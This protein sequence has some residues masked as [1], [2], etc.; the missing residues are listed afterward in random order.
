[1]EPYLQFTK[2]GPAQSS[3]IRGGR[4]GQ[5]TAISYPAEDYLWF[6]FWL[7]GFEKL[8]IYSIFG[9]LTEFLAWRGFALLHFSTGRQMFLK[10]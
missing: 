4:V 7:D 6:F 3:D 9:H 10:P 5:K 1:M 2:D 8:A